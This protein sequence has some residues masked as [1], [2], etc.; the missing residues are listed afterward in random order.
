MGGLQTNRL[1]ALRLAW[2]AERRAFECQLEG[3][4]NTDKPPSSGQFIA[5]AGTIQQSPIQAVSTSRLRRGT[6]LRS[7]QSMRAAWRGFPEWLGPPRFARARGNRRA[8]FGGYLLADTPRQYCR[9]V[10]ALASNHQPLGSARP[11]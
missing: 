1:A 7:S 5:M 4:N 3:P 2:L 9:G 6:G 8:R 10:S 11:A